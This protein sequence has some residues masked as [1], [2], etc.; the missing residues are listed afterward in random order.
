MADKEPAKDLVGGANYQPP[1]PKGK[2]N[3][4]DGTRT[5]E[6][7][8]VA[9]RPMQRATNVPVQ[10]PQLTESNYKL[11]AAKMKINMRPMGVWS[12][13]EDDDDYD[14]KDQGAMA[15]ISQSVPDDVMMMITEFDTAR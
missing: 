1:I 13:A 14:E 4:S 8:V 3:G 15:V 5:S 12:A 6:E 11:W 2:R 7:G 10:Y 9:M